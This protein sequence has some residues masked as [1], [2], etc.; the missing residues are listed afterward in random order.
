[1]PFQ[2]SQFILAG[3]LRGAGD[4][5]SVAIITFITVLLL[6]PGLAIIT[7]KA[8]GWGLEGAWYALVA[9]QLLRSL[10]VKLRY[11]SGVWKRA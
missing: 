4:T 8:L 7:V 9:D 2:T 6:R 11:H 3:A 5:R 1:Q 10:L